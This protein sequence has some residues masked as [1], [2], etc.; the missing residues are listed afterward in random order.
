MADENLIHSVVFDLELPASV[1]KDDAMAEAESCFDELAL[2]VIDEVITHFGSMYDIDMEQISIDLGMVSKE[3]LPKVLSE[4]LEDEL[5]KHLHFGLM[6]GYAKRAENASIEGNQTNEFENSSRFDELSESVRFSYLFTGVSP[7]EYEVSDTQLVETLWTDVLEILKDESRSVAFISRFSDEALALYRFLNLFDTER[8]MLFLKT[9]F[10]SHAKRKAQILQIIFKRVESDK[11]RIVENV[12]GHILS[13]IDTLSRRELFALVFAVFRDENVKGDEW[14]EIY[15]ESSYEFNRELSAG[16]QHGSYQESQSTKEM[17]EVIS[18]KPMSEQ[19][20]ENETI[21]RKLASE[22]QLSETTETE[23]QK[24]SSE[25][26]LPEMAA[27]ITEDS[28]KARNDSKIQLKEKILSEFTDEIA[29]LKKQAIEI[30]VHAAQSCYVDDAGLI[31]LHP[32]LMAL[33]DR[34]G[35]LDEDRKF[36]GLEAQEKAVH[37]LRWLAGFDKPHLDY[38]LA[39]EKILCGLP[40]TYPIAS[41]FELSEEE[42]VE[43]R[44]VLASVCKYWKPLNG[45][46]I[47]G[48]QQSFMRRN[49]KVIFEDNAWI[50]R[51]EGQTIDVLLDDLPWEI[52]LLLFP[53]KE[54]MIM[55]EWQR[56]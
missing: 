51:V 20:S 50:V 32:F 14:Q 19:F 25:T 38:Q 7:W 52:S 46:S 4:K 11:P 55:V 28:D 42:I 27:Y 29:L 26:L 13:F 33:F 18:L 23:V 48:L 54:E 45:T 41:E 10:L 53:W 2:P 6:E 21:A 43:G 15:V 44:Q 5:V 47:E 3:D 22:V 37:L 9:I 40:L 39:L 35:L 12:E 1:H 30:P 17:P 24:K 36:V 34:I 31:I 16:S 49:A 8:I 56:E